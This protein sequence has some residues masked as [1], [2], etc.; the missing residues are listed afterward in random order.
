[1][2]FDELKQNQMEE[3]EREWYLLFQFYFEKILLVENGK[4]ELKSYRKKNWVK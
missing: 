1:M 2:L 3:N 4:V